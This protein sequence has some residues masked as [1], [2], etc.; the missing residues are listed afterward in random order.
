MKVGIIYY[1]E[2]GHTLAACEALADAF[3]VVGHTAELARITVH[4]VK[5]DRTLKAIPVAEGYDYLVLGTPVQAGSPPLPVLTYLKQIRLKPGQPVG[6]IITQF[7]PW[8]CLGGTRTLRL[9]EAAFSR[10]AADIKAFGI[11]HWSSR[12]RAAQLAAAIQTIVDGA[13]GDSR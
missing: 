7:F 9:I 8:N 13:A 12:K 10:T 4:D 2:T 6:V 11:I 3:R 5:T 1:S